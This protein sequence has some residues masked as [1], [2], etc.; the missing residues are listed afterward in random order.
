MAPRLSPPLLSFHCRP[1]PWKHAAIPWQALASSSD[2]C[3][4]GSLVSDLL[5]LQN[6]Q[7]LPTAQW[8]WVKAT[9]SGVWNLEILPGELASPLT[10][11]SHFPHALL[12]TWEVLTKC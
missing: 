6:L 10:H 7:W 8:R 3:F 9:R 5:L 12:G 11:P 1:G 2:S 4:T